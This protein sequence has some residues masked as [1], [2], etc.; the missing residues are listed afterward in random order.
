V[1]GA[2]TAYDLPDLVGCVAPRKI[3]LFELKDHMKEKASSELV[4]KELDFPR[5]VYNS[6]NASENLKI[7]YY[8][9]EYNFDSVL[10]WW[11][12]K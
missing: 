6:K 8:D 10:D 3:I 5:S 12:K 2:L 7:L 9:S 1:A 4:N 11:I